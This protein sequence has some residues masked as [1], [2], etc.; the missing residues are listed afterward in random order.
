MTRVLVASVML[1][2]MLA[3]AA[4]AAAPLLPMTGRFVPTAHGVPASILLSGRLP[5]EAAGE[6]VWI[7]GRD[8]MYRHY[9]QITGTRSLRGGLWEATLGGSFG[10]P[11]DMSSGMT[12]RARWRGR[13]SVLWTFRWRVHPAVVK[14]RGNRIQVTVHN[15]GPL[16][17]FARKP[18]VLQ[19]LSGGEWVRSATARL[20]TVDARTFRATFV[21]RTRGLTLRALVPQE[22][23]RPCFNAGA[24]ANFTS[25]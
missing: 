6:Q 17:S 19:R 21:V 22:T 24:S 13:L 14:L 23:A 5:T 15:D 2:A 4:S 16:Q 20:R 11:D 3:A 12:Y 9:R 10:K 7:L 8:C 18:V 1:A 25:L